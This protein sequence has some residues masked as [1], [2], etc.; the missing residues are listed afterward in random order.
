MFQNPTPNR[1]TAS[2]ARFSSRKLEISVTFKK[3]SPKTFINWDLFTSLAGLW[4]IP[5]STTSTKNTIGSSHV[6]SARKAEVSNTIKRHHSRTSR[7]NTTT[8]SCERG[9]QRAVYVWTRNVQRCSRRWAQQWRL[10]LQ[11]RRKNLLRPPRLRQFY[12]MMTAPSALRRTI[13]SF[14]PVT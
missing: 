7:E 3:R 11:R 14:A 4:E 2:R 1:I 10:K 6:F 5:L 8:W 12:T 9:R 13:S